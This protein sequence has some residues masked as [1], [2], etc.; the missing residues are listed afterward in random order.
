MGRGDI[1]LVQQRQREIR[2]RLPDIKHHAQIVPHVQHLQ[3]GGVV[4]HRA[5]TGVN[6]NSIGFQPH[7]QR[8]IGQMPAPVGA[9]FKQRRVERQD[10]GLRCHGVQ[11]QKLAFITAIGARRIAQQGADAPG[12]QPLLQPPANIAN[13]HNPDGTIAQ[14]EPITFR[15]QQQRGED[16]LH[17]RD[18]VAAGRCGERDAC[19]L[20]SRLVDMIGA[21]RG[22]ADKLHRRARQQRLINLGDGAH[23]QPLSVGQFC[24]RQRTP[25]HR[26]HLAGPAEQLT[27]IGHIFIDQNFHHG[28]P[29]SYI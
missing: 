5:A 3:Q 1:D 21:C 13:P 2:L 27:G 24:H 14:L 16:I 4:H 20:Q 18:G 23:H 25:R 10:I 15:Q 9:L 12:F 8:R 17:N 28:F 22:G 29:V 7:Q 11:R 26:N 6:Q 19:P